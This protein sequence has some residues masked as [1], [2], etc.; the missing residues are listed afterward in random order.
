MLYVCLEGIREGSQQIPGEMEAVDLDDARR[1][2]AMIV[3]AHRNHRLRE[4]DWTCLPDTSLTAEER[5]AWQVHRQALR[6]LPQAPGFPDVPWPVPPTT[7]S[8][9]GNETGEQS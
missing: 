3:R 1:L 9:A 4:C 7:R 2:W 5:A 8:D 6:D